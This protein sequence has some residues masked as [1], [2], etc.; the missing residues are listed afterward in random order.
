[1]TKTRCSAACK[2]PSRVDNDLNIDDIDRLLSSIDPRVF[3]MHNVHDNSGPFPMHTRWA[4]S[5]LRGPLTRQQI[6]ILMTE[7]RAQPF[8]P[9]YQQPVRARSPMPQPYST[10]PYGTRR[11][12]LSQPPVPAR[13]DAAAHDP[14]GDAR[15][16]CPTPTPCP[17]LARPACRDALAAAGLDAQPRRAT[18]SRTTPPPR[19]RSRPT[20]ETHSRRAGAPRRLGSNL[21]EGFNL[22]PPPLP[23]AVAQYFLPSGSVDAAGGHRVGAA[24]RDA[25]RAYR[26]I[27]RSSTSR[28]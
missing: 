1:M 24:H 25:G 22:T 28:F 21:P 5:F 19:I 11:I 18:S 10:Q 12:P 27:A 17:I 14:A 2:A 15:Q 3:V 4:M 23:S 13:R 16:R 7:Q 20:G 26:R 9:S 6:R 8:Y